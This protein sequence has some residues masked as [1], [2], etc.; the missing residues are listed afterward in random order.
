MQLSLPS[1]LITLS[2]KQMEKTKLFTVKKVRMH[3]RCAGGSRAG[4]SIAFLYKRHFQ[5]SLI[6]FKIGTIE[7]PQ[8]A[9]GD[10][11]ESADLVGLWYNTSRQIGICER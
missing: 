4:A 3:L 2:L 6:P 8:A 10:E 1:G 9:A 11:V 7:K 5:E